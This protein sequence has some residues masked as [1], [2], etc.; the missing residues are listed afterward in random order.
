MIPDDQYPSF[1][2]V[3]AVIVSPSMRHLMELVERVARTSAAVLIV[4]ETGS[5]KEIVA[6]AIHHFSLRSS[7]PWVDVNCGA[8]PD[9]LMES[10]LFGHERGAF[11]GADT[12][13]PGLFELAHR[14]TLFL[15]EVAELEPRMQVKL[16][17]VLDGAPYFRVGGQ[18]K[19][20]VDVRILAATNRD[21]VQAV[22]AGGFRSDLYHRLNQCQMRVPPL[23]ERPEDIVPLAEHFLRAHSEQ[24]I[25]SSEAKEALLR[26]DW[27]GNARELRN[28]VISALIHS[29]GYEIL[30][31]DIRVPENGGGP[32][33]RVAGALRLDGLERDAI[34]EALQKTMGHHTQAAALL[35]IS[36]RTLSRKLKLY[37]WRAESDDLEEYETT[38]RS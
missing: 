23:R 35:G 4:G 10:E 8:L 32:P 22:R 38:S 1:L 11:S 36:R 20:E 29:R 12:A 34:F 33:S 17:R 9:Q 24:A 30:A 37:G 26:R 2:G 21:L 15:D 19:V 6:R 28:T 25:F 16:L 13:K 3:P 7:K 31:S 14:G 27:P 5:G 18:K